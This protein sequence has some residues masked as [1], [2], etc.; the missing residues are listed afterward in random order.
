M[1]FIKKSMPF[2]I[3]SSLFL[4]HSAVAGTINFIGTQLPEKTTVDATD[5]LCKVAR[6]VLA[7]N[8]LY[9]QSGE[10]HKAPWDILKKALVVNTLVCHYA[11][12]D[13]T[14]AVTITIAKDPEGIKFTALPSEFYNI[15]VKD[16][17]DTDCNPEK[18]D[19]CT[20]KGQGN[21]DVVLTKKSS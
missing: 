14:A 16:E 4:S 13:E 10:T 7:D 18:P 11:D 15:E 21:L 17:D 9:F 19:M 1:T 5:R 6:R 12:K 3:A 20:Y 2:I 8:A